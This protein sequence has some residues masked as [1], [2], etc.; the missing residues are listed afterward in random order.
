VPTV[1]LH[2]SLNITREMVL[3]LGEVL[4][5]FYNY[6]KGKTTSKEDSWES[7]PERTGDYQTHVEFC[8]QFC[9]HIAPFSEALKLDGYY[10]LP[11][12]FEYRK[13]K[14][15][16]HH[17]EIMLCKPYEGGKLKLFHE[18]PLEGRG[19]NLTGTVKN[20]REVDREIEARERAKVFLKRQKTVLKK[21]MK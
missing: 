20:A 4:E 17:E 2:N 5:R 10:S 21:N 16:V 9:E 19:K 14:W 12:K 18:V 13:G 11:V 8:K 3:R 1:I 15:S 6:V 7:V